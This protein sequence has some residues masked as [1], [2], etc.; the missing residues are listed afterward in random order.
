VLEFNAQFDKPIN[1]LYP[2]IL[3]YDCLR[4]PSSGSSGTQLGSFRIK[5]IAVTNWF[6]FKDRPNLKAH[7][8]IFVDRSILMNAPS[9]I[10]EPSVYIELGVTFKTKISGC[11]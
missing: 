8:L 10:L 1:S 7:V 2:I 9:I 4:G 3:N 5:A 6:M 11:L